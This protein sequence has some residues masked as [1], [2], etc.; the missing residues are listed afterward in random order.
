MS[1]DLAARYGGERI[2]R[3]TSYPTA[4]HFSKNIGADSY[5]R[6]LESISADKIASLYL[7]IPFC[8][9]MCWYCGCQTGIVRR[10]DPVS[11]YLNALRR[12]IETVAARIDHRLAVNHIHLGGGTPTITPINELERLFEL[13]RQRFDVRPTAE[14]AIEIDPRIFAPLMLQTL[15]ASGVNRMSFGVQSFDS[16]VQIAINRVQSFDETAAVVRQSRKAGVKGINFDLIYGL[17]H[18]NV[19]SCIDTIRQCLKIKP[20][21]FSVFGY[22]HVPEFKKHQRMIDSKVL[23]DSRERHSQSEVMS[24]MLEDAG[25]VRIGL[26]HFALPD[27]RMAI[28]QADGSL[29]RNFQGYTTDQSNVL[30]GFGASA[31]GQLAQGYIQNE[32]ATRPYVDLA[33]KGQLATARGY[34]LTDDDRL[35]ADII[36]RLMCDYYADIEGICAR[37]GVP[38]AD[39]MTLAPRLK[40]LVEDGVVQLQGSSV[41]VAEDKQ[42]LV[43]SVAAAFDAHLG[44]MGRRHSRA[45]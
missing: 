7:H 44:L 4:P 19:E 43:R 37:H 31:I 12:E 35:R 26:D 21:R 30:L 23:P 29:K 11:D 40:P 8:R 45:I 5:G 24:A 2:P 42:F 18:Q 10:Q 33:T 20:E 25:Y 6:W 38:F 39:S 28:A 14:I 15:V 3:Y 16:K 9:S 27:D 13:M 41:F 32:P 1:V 34:L 36:E 17:P 22:A